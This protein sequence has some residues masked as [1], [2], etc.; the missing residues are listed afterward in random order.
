MKVL[1]FGAVACVALIAASPQALAQQA[2]AGKP[3]TCWDYNT[4][5]DNLGSRFRL[6]GAVDDTILNRMAYYSMTRLPAKVSAPL[7]QL[8]NTW[9]NVEIRAEAEGADAPLALSG[10]LVEL[11]NVNIDSRVA[12]VKFEDH[13]DANGKLLYLRLVPLEARFRAGD[14]TIIAPFRT[15]GPDLARQDVVLRLGAF[16]P[17][18]RPVGGGANFD[19]KVT[20][21]LAQKIEAAWRKAGTITIEIGLP[22]GGAVVATS[23]A[24]AYDSGKV[25]AEFAKMNSRARE[26]ISGGKCQY[27]E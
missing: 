24:L 4:L 20:L 9:F 10:L 7:I 26:M 6:Q 21:P 17:P 3:A 15:Q 8:S 18:T 1:A 2:T 14:D 22:D 27:L 13:V 5:A 25:D 19:P 11:D 12:A 23:G 16:A